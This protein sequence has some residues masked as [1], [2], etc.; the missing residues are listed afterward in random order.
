MV[1]CGWPLREGRHSGQIEKSRRVLRKMVQPNV[2][3]RRAAFNVLASG[4]GAHVAKWL[5]RDCES[6]CFGLRRC[7]CL[8]DMEREPGGCRGASLTCIGKMIRADG[9][10]SLVFSS[11][12]DSL[13]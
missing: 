12:R 8:C 1:A 7:E 4:F 9:A 11:I 2:V 13:A 5:A 10:Q 6:A 3:D